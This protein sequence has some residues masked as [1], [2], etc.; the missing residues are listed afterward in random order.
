MKS[1]QVGEFF[2]EIEQ[3]SQLLDFLL[4]RL[5]FAGFSLPV[6]FFVFALGHDLLGALLVE[7]SFGLLLAEAGNAGGID[8]FS[9]EQ[10]PEFTGLVAG[11]GKFENAQFFC[12]GKSS[13][14]RFLDHLGIGNQMLALERRGGGGRLVG[15]LSVLGDAFGN[16]SV[17]GMNLLRPD[18]LH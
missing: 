7:L 1:Q 12:G 14:C 15:C 4:H 16:Q 2:L 3:T 17:H 11:V 18:D 13:P 8:S 9:S 10:R 5:E 6:G